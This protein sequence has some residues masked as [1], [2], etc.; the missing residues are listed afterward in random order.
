MDNLEA[1]KIVVEAGKKLVDTGLIARTWGNVSCRVS[2]TQF[3]ITPSGRAYETLTPDEI[4]TV[5]IADCS[6]EG[7]LEPSSEKGVHAEIY[8]QRPDINFVIHTHQHYASAVSPLKIDI[9]VNEPTA[10]ALIGSKVLSIPYG[11]PGSKTLRKNVAKALSASTGKAYLMVSHGALCLGE[12]C[13]E[14]FSVAAELEKVCAE[15]VNHHYCKV[16][17]RDLIDP[18]EYGDYIVSLFPGNNKEPG[19]FSA[20]RVGNSERS[21]G[22]FM[23]YHSP[24]LKGPFPQGGND[25]IAVNLG[26]DTEE[27][28]SQTLLPAAL[29]HREIYR[30][31]D[32]INAIIHTTSF[33][34]LIVSLI[35]RTIYPMLDDFAQIIGVNVQTACVPIEEDPVGASLEI[36]EKIKGRSAVLLKNNGALCCGPTKSDALAAV[37]IMEKN[38]RAFIASCIFD[39]GKPIKPIEC[40]LMRYVYLKRYSKKASAQQT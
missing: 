31:Y 25:V 14:A 23:L 3:V 24:T 22:G 28:G 20:Q 32:Q 10:Q 12:D 35:G 33:D 21:E 9:S 38:C 4:V 2:D 29:I 27:T 34:I 17:G 18:V 13:E 26:N 37:M 7:D 16:S 39:R 6:Y 1:R 19:K 40:H 8:R 5:N 36:T 30:N 11:L 15:F